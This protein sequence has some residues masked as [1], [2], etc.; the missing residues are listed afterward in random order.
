MKLGGIH[1]VL[2]G[3]ILVGAIL[4]LHRLAE[5]SIWFDEAVAHTTITAFGWPEMVERTGRAVHPPGFYI[6]LRVWAAALGASLISLRLFSVLLSWIAIAAAYLLGRELAGPDAPGAPRRVPA[7]ECG[8]FAA[9]LLSLS[10]FHIFWSQQARMYSL[11]TALTLLS[12]WLFLKAFLRHAGHPSWLAAYAGSAVLLIYTHNFGLFIVLA[13][14]V[15]F[16]LHTL[17]RLITRTGARQSTGSLVA[18]G[19]A[20]VG[21]AGAYAAW[22]PTLAR[23]TARVRGD[24]WIPPID[25]WRVVDAWYDLFIPRNV[26]ARPDELVLIAFTATM[27]GILVLVVWFQRPEDWFL[28]CLIT[29]PVAAAVLISTSIASIVVNRYFLFAQACMLCAIA[30]VVARVRPPMVR[31]A[32][33]CFILVNAGL[34]HA[35]YWDA[36]GV[37]HKPGLNGAVEYVLSRKAKHERIVVIHPSIYHSVEYCLKG[38]EDP[39]LAGD[40]PTWSHYKGAPL[41]KAGEVRPFR[42]IPL[43]QGDRVWV[44]DTSGFQSGLERPRVPTTWAPITE[45][46]AVFPEVIWWQ[47]EIIVMPYTVSSEAPRAPE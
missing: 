24:Y 33:M 14:A 1:I 25:G 28:I 18:F 4:R 17:M 30:L 3:A 19:L 13:H 43:G 21:I 37:A 44:F 31:A 20:F 32:A 22:L 35:R 26:L 8:L 47:K 42:E 11:G 23:Q 9:A 27:I 12:S 7:L 41:L 45:E 29:V 10:S 5:R 39:I 34:V 2:L 15:F 36:L 38:I 6:L 40:D 16:A 46:G